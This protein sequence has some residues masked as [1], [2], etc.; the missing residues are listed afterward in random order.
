MA[1]RRFSGSPGEVL[2]EEEAAG[3]DVDGDRVHPGGA[4][5]GKGESRGE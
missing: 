5:G 1:A 3:G 2:S 4:G